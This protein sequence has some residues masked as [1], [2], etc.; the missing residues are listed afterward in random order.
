METKSDSQRKMPSFNFSYDQPPCSFYSGSKALGEEILS[1][2]EKVYTC[3]LR[4]PFD[5]FDSNRNYLSKIQRYDK[6]YN[7]VNSISHREEFVNACL[8]LPFE[9]MRLWDLQCNQRRVC[10]NKAS[11]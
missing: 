8:D 10:Y 4:I 2:F 9:Q 6:V 11:R 3:R 5:E 7:A 1:K